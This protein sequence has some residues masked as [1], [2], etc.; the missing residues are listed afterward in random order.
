MF[1]RRR[2]DSALRDEIASQLEEL[3]KNRDN[4]EK[5]AATLDR[6]AKLDKLTPPKGA[7]MPPSMDTVLICCANI[8]GVLWLARFER[9]DV[10]KAPNA[11]RSV[12]R[13]K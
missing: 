4:P 12:I 7:L 1:S 5:Y 9:E 3:A 6:I 11:F 2:I 8:F 13:L 10:I